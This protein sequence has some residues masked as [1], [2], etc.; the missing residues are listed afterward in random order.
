MA[1]SVGKT[2]D[3]LKDLI[4]RC[5]G[6]RRDQARFGGNSLRGSSIEFSKMTGTQWHPMQRLLQGNENVIEEFIDITYQ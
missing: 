5:G 4:V 2:E 3:N 1:P 6:K